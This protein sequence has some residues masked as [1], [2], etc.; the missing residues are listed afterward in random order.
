MSTT[1]AQPDL[2]QYPIS[3]LNL[4]ANYADRAAY[5]AAVGTE[6]PP[7]NPALP[8]KGWADPAPN[9]EPYLMFD[10]ASPPFYTVEL[11]VPAS[12]AVTVN[13][14][15]AYSYPAYV[16]VPTDAQMMGPYGPVGPVPAS[17]LC[18]EADA[19][20]VASAIAPL[21][22]GASLTV[23]DNSPAGMIYVLYGT[24]PRRMW[25][26][27]ITGI[28]NIAGM[29]AAITTIMIDYAQALI[30]AQ[31]GVGAGGTGWGVGAPGHWELVSNN[32]PIGPGL[33]GPTILPG[34]VQDPQI[35][36]P[37]PNAVTLAVPIRPLLPNEQ[38]QLVPPSNP[39]FGQ[40]GWMVV[41]T[42]M[43]PAI[44]LTEVQQLVAQYNAQPGVTAIAIA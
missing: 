25:G 10:A 7:F 30:E 9:G 4:F 38:F 1:P 14:P 15:G 21:Y 8:I 32:G 19:Q 28:R 39:L 24:D 23:V 11:A 16:E 5:L 33:V 12:A 26:I 20:A 42:D 34:W 40:A 37:P 43:P 27:S 13:L 18:L 41:R 31:A 29:S 17:E 44:T 36:V 22:P 6:A 2:P 3:D 35:T